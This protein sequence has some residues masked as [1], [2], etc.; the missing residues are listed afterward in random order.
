MRIEKDDLD[1]A[2]GEL[3]HLIFVAHLSETS[4]IELDKELFLN[5]MHVINSQPA[6]VRIEIDQILNAG[7]YMKRKVLNGNA[8]RKPGSKAPDD[9]PGSVETASKIGSN[10]GSEDRE[11]MGIRL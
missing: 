3:Q 11:E 6:K 2:L 10:S 1:W 7:Y 8:R 9:S 4:A 5:C